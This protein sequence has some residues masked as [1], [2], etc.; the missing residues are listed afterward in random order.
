MSE[1]DNTGMRQNENTHELAGMDRSTYTNHITQNMS[2]FISQIQ[3]THISN[4]Y[5]D[6]VTSLIVLCMLPAISNAHVYVKSHLYPS[7]ERPSK[8]T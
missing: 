5:I 6:C 4:K 7:T 1:E 3:D 2:T 8:N